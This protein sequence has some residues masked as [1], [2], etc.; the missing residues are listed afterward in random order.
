MRIAIV[1]EGIDARRGGAETSVLQMAAALRDLGVD[2][3]L[4]AAVTKGATDRAGMVELPVRVLNCAPSGRTRAARVSSF[5]HDAAELCRRERFDVVHAAA[6]IWSADVYQPRGGTY[7]E[8]IERS[9]AA[10]AAGGLARAVR[11]A[12]RR[13]NRRQ[14]TLLE[15]ERALLMRERPP[16]V[17]AV[18][19]YVK[20]QAIDGYGLP[21][22]RVRVVFN[23]VSIDPL[24]RGDAAG[25]RATLRSR[26][27]AAFDAPVVLFV[28]HNFKLKGLRQLI[29]A[30]ALRH[31]PAWH[32]WVAGR[33]KPKPYQRAAERLGVAP[34]VRFI[35]ADVPM[36]SLFAAADLLAHP[37][38]YDP[39]SRVVLEA[40]ACGLPVVTT[41][42]N[43]A[44]EAMRPEV[45]GHIVESP[46]HLPALATAIERCLSPE[47]RRACAADAPRFRDSVS[48]R[49]HARELLA[50]FEAIRGIGERGA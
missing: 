9:L 33:D 34:R 48:M 24:S 11:R 7:R 13:L 47:L 42:W 41:R 39:C 32:L 46:R 1:N 45:H 12:A 35:G 22:E 28:A 31:G 44:A 37:T 16:V 15:A 3:T 25:E 4:V 50:L 23:G 38:F 18:S 17:A 43:G 5:L 30:A 29:R 6:P 8:T 26:F 10:S 21:A 2:V 14:R 27:G 19:E 49:R 20:R 40:L 36:R